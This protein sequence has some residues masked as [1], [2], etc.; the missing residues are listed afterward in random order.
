MH[1]LSSPS[2]PFHPFCRP[3]L[4]ALFI[5]SPPPSTL[6]MLCSSDF[7]SFPYTLLCPSIFS[8]GTSNNSLPL[9]PSH[10]FLPLILS[11]LLLHL[12]RY[13]FLSSTLA[14]RAGFSA[15]PRPSTPFSSLFSLT[16]FIFSISQRVSSPDPRVFP[17]MSKSC[18]STP[19]H[20]ILHPSPV[21]FSSS[22][23]SRPPLHLVFLL[24][25]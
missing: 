17:F 21:I 19:P 25:D 12:H 8:T 13:S 11:F 5:P 22:L 15:Q 24:K 1:F 7:F 10:F 18:S 20:S 16:Y 3:P 14:C 6:F 9:T 4:T 2:L 23:T